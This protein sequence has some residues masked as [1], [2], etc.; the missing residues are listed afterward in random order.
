MKVSACCDTPLPLPGTIS[1]D[2]DFN[3]PGA[4]MEKLDL[5]HSCLILMSCQYRSQRGI[6]FLKTDPD[7]TWDTNIN[8]V[9]SRT[10]YAWQQNLYTDIKWILPQSGVVLHTQ[11]W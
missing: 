3:D 8:G 5:S 7:I 10:V 6:S 1:L 9:L 11:L 4:E 2:H